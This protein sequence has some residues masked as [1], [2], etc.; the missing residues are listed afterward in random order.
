MSE[1]LEPAETYDRSVT[2]RTFGDDG[3]RREIECGS[4]EEAIRE[5]K[6][7]RDA[8]EVVEITAKDG[9]VVFDSHE[10]DIEGWALEWRREKRSLS[11]DVERRECPHDSVAC[12]ADARCIACQIDAVQEQS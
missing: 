12:F 5:V 10:M 2:V 1:P 3:E 7:A 4:Y 11:V 6:L 8:V 9:D